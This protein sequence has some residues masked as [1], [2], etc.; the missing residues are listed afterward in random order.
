[1]S[2][3]IYKSSAGSGKTY[4]L[5]REYLQIVIA[6]PRAYKNVLAITF[7]NKATAEMKSRIIRFLSG[8]ADG[9]EEVLPLSEALQKATGLSEKVVAGRAQEVLTNIL[10]DYGRF[11]ATTIDSFF[12]FVLKSFS[13]ELGL[14][15]QYDMELD[16]SRMIEWMVDNMLLCTEDDKELEDWL[17]KYVY[18]QIAEGKSVPGIK[19]SFAK[20]AGELFSENFFRITSAVS[21]QEN[22]DLSFFNQVIAR[23]N[24]YRSEIKT[25]F[26]QCGKEA[27]DTCL[28]HNLCAKDFFQSSRG[29]YKF[30]ENLQNFEDAIGMNS[31]VQQCLEDPEK[32]VGAKH[33]SRN[34]IMPLVYE[35]LYPKLQEAN[36]LMQEFYQHF[37]TAG[38]IL[39]NIYVF[40]VLNYLDE[41]KKEYI[42]EF[43][44]I[45]PWETLGYINDI[46]KDAE[47]APFVFEKTGTYIKHMLIDE[48]QDTSMVQWASLRPL[49]ENVLA[50]NGRVVIVGDVKQSI[51]RWRGGDLSLLMNQIEDELVV[52]NPES[53]V[54]NTNWRSCKNIIEFNNSLYDQLGMFSSYPWKKLAKVYEGHR[55]YCKPGAPDKGYVEVGFLDDDKENGGW[56]AKAAELTIETID[57]L[58]NRNFRFKDIGIVIRKNSEGVLLASILKEAGIPFIS[59]ESLFVQ[60]APVV[61]F[62]VA[63]LKL[64]ADNND[65]VSANLAAKFSA[66]LKG[67]GIYDGIGL[68]GIEVV[69]GQV[70]KVAE[71]IRPMNIYEAVEYLIKIFALEHEA[72]AY[73]QRFQ[74]LALEYL[75]KQGT[76]IYGFVKWWDEEIESGKYS[77]I[78]PE[79]EDAVQIVTIHKSKGLE[80]PVVIL[81]FACW[82]TQ[83]KSGSVFWTVVPEPERYGIPYVPLSAG[84][85]L[86]NSAFA[87]QYGQEWENNFTD[88][89]NSLYVAT[90]RA[91]KELYLFT[92]KPNK[93]GLPEYDTFNDLNVFLYQ[94]CKNFE[95][96]EFVDDFY[97][98]GE[99][100]EEE[101]QVTTEDSAQAKLNSYPAKGLMPLSVAESEKAVSAAVAKGLLLHKVLENINSHAD[102]NRAVRSAVDEGLFQLEEQE[103]FVAHLDELLNADSHLQEWFS[104]DQQ[105]RNYRER[106]LYDAQND[107]IYRPDRIMTRGNKVVVLDYKVSFMDEEGGDEGV[108]SLLL[109]RYKR[110]MDKYAG[111]LQRC[112]FAHVETY[113]LFTE[114]K[115][116]LKV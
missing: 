108:E 80:Y 38:E 93:E 113:L 77:V 104:D 64:S 99:K 18:R 55:Q 19:Q 39:K 62:I 86:M 98:R 51:Y 17:K 66:E 60:N 35:Q 14:Y 67:V 61:Q 116:L 32:W 91:E 65:G 10:H 85:E 53:Q 8:L 75:N 106:E 43:R 34:L 49:V 15:M 11:S 105:W 83:P 23:L 69:S 89:V 33:K 115:K 78:V 30:F 2:L 27:L 56:K 50:G 48:A 109:D 47:D 79:G 112:G 94:A 54:L 44:Q 102:I 16:N 68:V 13:A 103:A 111:L 59:S 114:D 37:L 29:V 45:T 58:R 70:F 40:G 95:V 41:M 90:T 107:K 92:L 12:Q 76:D 84:K 31:Y 26:R 1:M 73:L 96:G 46:I 88:E 9:K 7:T 63:I 42:A 71:H 28:Q 21:F 101:A 97:S 22:L 74:D 87:E 100:L 25:Q 110:Q 52:F 3:T 4:N 72:P 5:A 6:N 81:P 20:L 24:A 36:E 82:P 57:D